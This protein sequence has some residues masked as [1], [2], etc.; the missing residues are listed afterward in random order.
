MNKLCFVILIFPAMVGCNEST[1]TNLQRRG[2]QCRDLKGTFDNAFRAN[3]QVFQDYGYVIKNAD[4]DSGVIQGATA[5]KRHK[6]YFWN[7]LMVSSEI[8]A[9]LEQFQDDL[10]KERITIVDKTKSS[11]QYGTHENS[12]I[13]ETPATYQRIYDDIR[14]EIFVRKNLNK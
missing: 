2:M 11:S 10:V 13:V 1:M 3:L 7:R 12:K 9:T 4:Y 14:K 5:T 6:S 8:T